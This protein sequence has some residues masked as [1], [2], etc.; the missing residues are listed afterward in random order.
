MVDKI[1]PARVVAY[2]LF[3]E[4]CTH[5]DGYYVKDL[6][7]LGRNLKDTIIVDVEM[8]IF[9]IIYFRIQKIHSYFRDKMLIIFPIFSMI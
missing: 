5:L 8:F 7:R 3:R 9:L 4:S 6:S 2:K 1:D